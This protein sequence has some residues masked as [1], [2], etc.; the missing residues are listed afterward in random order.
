MFMDPYVLNYTR[1][2]RNPCPSPTNGICSGP[3]ARWNNFRANLGYVLRYSRK[4]NLANVTP[5]SSLCSTGNCLAQ[6]PSV[7]AEYLIYAP[8]GGSFTVNLS[9]MSSARTLNVEWLNP[10]TGA[11]TT[12]SPIPAGSS[13][14]SFTPP[15]SGDAVLYL[16]DSAGHA[17][18]AVAP[19]TSYSVTGLG[20]GTY[21]YQVRAIDAA[22]NAGPFSNVAGATIQTPDTTPPT[23]PSGLTATT[24][25]TGQ[26]GLSW[27]A[28]TDNVAVTG[29]LVERC[30]GAGCASFA[31]VA[32]PAGTGTTFTDSGLAASTS[33]TYRVRATDAANNPGPYSNTATVTTVQAPAGITLVQ[34]AN[35]DAGSVT[36]SSLAFTSSNAAGQLG[37]G[38]D[39]RMAIRAVADGGGCAGQHLPKGRPAE[40]NGR[41]HDSRDLLR[42]EHRGRLEHGDRVR[43]SVGRY[44][45]IRH[46]RVCGRGDRGLAGRDGGLARDQRRADDREWHD[47]FERRPRD[48]RH[49]DG[50]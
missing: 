43:Y 49:S 46:S 2:G 26:V 27:T 40:R 20:P 4:L 30:Q 10:S 45:A 33:Y 28:S 22:G 17:G 16:V 5:R 41:R 47:D 1:E 6:T 8:N 29:Y 13:S 24:A 50:Q 36:S 34:H 18:A 15:F 31:Q 37:G 38:G 48:W 44:P 35:K 25:G 42:R 19:Q 7:G 12:A 11:T 14:R 23:A 21:R 3:D 39:P 9:A 32:A